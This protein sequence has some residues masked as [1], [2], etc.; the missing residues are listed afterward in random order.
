VRDELAALSI[1][2]D[3]RMA[4]EALWAKFEQIRAGVFGAL[5]D[6]VACALDHVHDVRLDRL[7]RMADFAQWATAAE[8]AFGWEPGTFIEVYGENRDES[9]EVALDSSTIGPALRAVADAGFHGTASELL[10]KLGEEAGE[11]ATKRKDWP[12]PRGLVD[13]LKRLAPNMR[14]LGYLVEQGARSTAAPASGRSRSP[15]D[16][17]EGVRGDAPDVPD[18]PEA[19]HRAGSRGPTTSPFRGR[20]GR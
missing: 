15:D 2:E 3:N 12:N 14:A 7:P 18:V 13:E 8:P 9:H 17:Q 1:P 16:A 19:A 10:E 5:C 20:R 6:A 11:R 4:E